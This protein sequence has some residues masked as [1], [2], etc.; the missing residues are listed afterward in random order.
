MNGASC[1]TACGAWLAGG[2]DS[3]PGLPVVQVALMLK[4]RPP[5]ARPGVASLV[6]AA[7]SGTPSLPSAR[8]AAPCSAPPAPAAGLGVAD[9]V[10]QKLP[11]LE[12]LSPAAAA[13]PVQPRGHFHLHLRQQH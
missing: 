10:R 3:V 4:I 12:R 2:G 5:V 9:Q 7:G 8:G 13:I 1:G 11:G 6:A